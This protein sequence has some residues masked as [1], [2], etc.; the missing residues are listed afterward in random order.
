MGETSSA[1]GACAAA[2]GSS[3]EGL[4]GPSVQYPPPRSSSTERG[5]GAE[6]PGPQP[7]AEGG[8]KGEDE[9]RGRN[10]EN[11][12]LWLRDDRSSWTAELVNA[13][14][15][16]ET[17]RAWGVDWARCVKNFFDFEAAWGWIGRGWKWNAP[18]SL[19]EPLGTRESDDWTAAW[20]TW[21][22]TLQPSERTSVN[23]ELSRP[24]TADWSRLA[25]RY[26]KNGLLQVM[27]TLCWWG[28]SAA[29]RVK[30]G[31]E[32]DKAKEWLLA[33]EDVAWVLEQ[34][35]GSRE[36]ER[37]RDDE[38]GEMAGNKRKR[39]DEG[40]AA[41]PSKRAKEPMKEVGGRSVGRRRD[42]DNETPPVHPRAIMRSR[43]ASAVA[44]PD[45]HP[46]PKPVRFWKSSP[47]TASRGIG[48]IGWEWASIGRLKR[49]GTAEL[50]GK[51]GSTGMAAVE[52]EDGH[53]KFKK[54]L[55]KK[56]KRGIYK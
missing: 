30:R 44:E 46:K 51:R 14:L 16:C 34:L 12:A 26:G 55:K 11:D 28:E 31:V 13:H 1:P 56:K 32:P 15:A 5:A 54:I 38:P 41:D 33:V 25:L 7:A 50:M 20:W 45:P 40:A 22:R 3:R 35:L 42:D 48:G 37:T 53:T 10:D 47:N 19:G 18:P 9:G 21:W 43:P 4:A 49:A 39:Q 36:I 27:A 6:E 2:V 8:G 23:G 17:G 24:E 52:L 29:K